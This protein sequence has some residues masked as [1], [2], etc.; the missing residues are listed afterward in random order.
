[1]FLFLNPFFHRTSCIYNSD[2][3]HQ[4]FK[5]LIVQNS[6]NRR[7]TLILTVNVWFAISVSLLHWYLQNFKREEQNFVVQN[8]INNMSFLIMDSKCKI[9]KVRLID[10]CCSEKLIRIVSNHLFYFTS[11]NH[12]RPGKE[13]NEEEDRQVFQTNKSYCCY[14]ETPSTCWNEHMC[15]RRTATCHTC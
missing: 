9:S 5:F 2:E 1:M 14:S 3:I 13:K 15:S 10:R 8:E 12:F 7:Q 4:S 6:E 11:G